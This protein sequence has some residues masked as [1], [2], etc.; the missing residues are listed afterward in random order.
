[1]AKSAPK[2][3]SGSTPPTDFAKTVPPSE[4]NPS[5]A[6]YRLL[7]KQMDALNSK[8]DHLTKP[9]TWRV[10]DIVALLGAVIAMAGLIGG[11]FALSDRINQSEE[12]LAQ[13]Q[14]TIMEDV[15][16]IRDDVSELNA[17]AM[18]LED[19]HSRAAANK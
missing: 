18:V 1:M 3:G 17:R 2:N 19:R 10:G 12:R 14:R 13:G 16:S 8:F 6:D 5:G 11:G 4:L 9:P 15:R 7:V